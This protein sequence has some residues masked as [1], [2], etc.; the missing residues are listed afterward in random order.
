[1]CIHTKFE[2]DCFNNEEDRA[3]IYKEH[4]E[5]EKGDFCGMVGSRKPPWV[6]PNFYISPYELFVEDVEIRNILQ[7]FRKS[8]EK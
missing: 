5:Y 8:V 1:M 7:P 2:D 6:Y 4:P 3:G